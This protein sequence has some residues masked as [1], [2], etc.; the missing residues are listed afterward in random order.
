MNRSEFARLY[1]LEYPRVFRYLFWRLRE[2][3]AAEELAAEVFATALSVFQKGTE[4]RQVG[5]WVVGIADRLAMRGRQPRD[6]GELVSG[7]DLTAEIGPEERALD[8]LKS[9]VLRRCVNALNPEL[10]QVLLLRVVAGLTAEEVGPLMCKT[11]E[12]VRSLQLRALQ[13]LR[14]LW[15]EADAGA[16]IR[17]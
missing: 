4:P 6:L 11:E 3:D 1:D 8:R 13:T 14:A 15:K 9:G 12:D 7:A 17:N 10:R 2:R 16:S 5:S